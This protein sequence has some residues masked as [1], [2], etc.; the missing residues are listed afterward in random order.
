[1]GTNKTLP[2]VIGSRKGSK[3]S[4]KDSEDKWNDKILKLKLI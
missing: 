4:S 3:N 1:M 2:A